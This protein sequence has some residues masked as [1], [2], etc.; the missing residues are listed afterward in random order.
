MFDFNQSPYNYL[1]LNKG[2]LF[3]LTCE[4]SIS[5]LEKIDS[6]FQEIN[7]LAISITSDPT[8][9]GSYVLYKKCLNAIDAF[10]GDYSKLV[11][12]TKLSLGENV[13]SVPSK[14]KVFDMFSYTPNVAL[15]Q[16]VVHGLRNT[17]QHFEE[18]LQEHDVKIN[19]FLKVFYEGVNSSWQVAFGSGGYQTKGNITTNEKFEIGNLYYESYEEIKKPVKSLSTTKI[20]LLDVWEDVLKIKNLL[21]E[22]MEKVIKDNGIC[23]PPPRDVGVFF[24][25]D[26]P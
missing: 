10:L 24:V 13:G 21:T 11:K 19:P 5:L 9:S 18:R 6:H 20:K 4:Y 8:A 14:K 23:C 1:P 15:Q 12:C 3:D 7:S 16:I 2:D 25:P 22:N 26:Q 17:S